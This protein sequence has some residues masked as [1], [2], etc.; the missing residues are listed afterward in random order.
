MMVGA[1]V[2][3][4][5]AAG[6]VFLFA[7]T[8]RGG[9]S[10]TYFV[11][12]DNVA[13]LKF[14]TGVYYE[15]YHIG[16]VESITPEPSADGMTYKLELS[17]DAGWRIPSDSVARVSSSGLI[18]AITIDIQE[19]DAKT[20]LKPGATITGEGQTDLF[21][22]INQA[23]GDFRTL[24]RKGI[25][26]MLKNLNGR[27]GEVADEIV[28][29]RREDL[30]PLV[31]MLHQRID[32]DIIEQASGMLRK[33]DRSAAALQGILGR[34]NQARIDSF[35]VNLEG[36]AINVKDL[37][38]GIEATRAQLNAVLATLERLLAEN[39]SELAGTMSSAQAS[40][41]E[42]ELAL[43]T[44][45]QHLSQILHNVEGGSH[46]MNEFARTIREN[47]ARLLRNSQTA[48]PGQQP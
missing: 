23:A 10:D 13:G 21:A 17:V 45:N 25:M 44:V 38:A 1:F 46:N 20:A 30:T 33:L 22:V 11:V 9:P 6:L 12:Y 40:M 48:E 35:L 4:M 19:G 32:R 14:G 28:K 15:G 39:E 26:P 2:L 8:G 36:A 43:K 18:S 34:Q 29:F 16:Q 27:I 31:S 42:L 24:S 7:I 37:I 5:F 47:P 3:L 41:R